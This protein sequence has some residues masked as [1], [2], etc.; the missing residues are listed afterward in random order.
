LRAIIPVIKQAL[1][2][3]SCSI[4]DLEAIYP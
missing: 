3:A 2:Q 4:D 1:E